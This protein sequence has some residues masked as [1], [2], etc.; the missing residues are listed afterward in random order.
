MKDFYHLYRY[1]TDSEREM[2]TV[3]K[4]Q[5][6]RFYSG[7]M[8]DSEYK[9]LSATQ[10]RNLTIIFVLANGSPCQTPMKV[11]LTGSDL[12]VWDVTLAYLATILDIPNGIHK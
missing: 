3:T 4:K 12:L 11:V 2:R 9:F 1:K 8:K 7:E 5:V 10:K 6:K